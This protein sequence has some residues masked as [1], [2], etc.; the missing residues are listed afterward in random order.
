MIIYNNFLEVE[1]TDEM[2]NIAKEHAVK[3][4]ERIVRQFFPG[5][6]A[7]SSELESNYYGCIGELAVK[8]YLNLPV[9][10]DDNY[11]KGK[12]D[13]GDVE[14]NNLSYDVKTTA[15]LST[16]YNKMY[17]GKILPYDSYGMIDYTSKHLH[18]LHK[19]T[20]G[21][22]FCTFEIPDDA[23]LTKKN[24]EIRDII[25]DNNYVLIL[26]YLKQNEITKNRDGSVRK[27]TW[28]GPRNP[29][30]GY[31]VKYQSPNYIYHHTE[32]RSVREIMEL[33][34]LPG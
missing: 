24:G 20:G 14:Y 29:D 26:G 31:Q 2:H 30:T 19:Y 21:V 12:T 32:L 18:H 11:E 25:T 22:I 3:R 10:L 17:T 16:F 8:K 1:L 28:R 34:N 27:P 13:S 15:R 4:E 23:K 5:K 7:P 33:E 9:E 6:N